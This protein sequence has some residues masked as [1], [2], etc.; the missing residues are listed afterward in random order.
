MRHGEPWTTPT[1]ARLKVPRSPTTLTENARWV[2]WLVR[3]S[4]AE[5]DRAEVAGLWTPPHPF[6]HPGHIDPLPRKVDPLTRALRAPA[7]IVVPDV[8][9]MIAILWPDYPGNAVGRLHRP[10]GAEPVRAGA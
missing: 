9:V 7:R 3:E 6:H 8:D 4:V 10:D 2:R 5:H 1:G